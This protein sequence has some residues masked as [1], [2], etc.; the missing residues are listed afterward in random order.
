MF[1][2]KLLEDF[3]RTVSGAFISKT[4]S[5]KY[6]ESRSSRQKRIRNKEN[7]EFEDS[8]FSMGAHHRAQLL[9]KYWK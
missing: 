9:Q 4:S 5:I 8:L 7:K 3:S 6:Q 1:E 2:F